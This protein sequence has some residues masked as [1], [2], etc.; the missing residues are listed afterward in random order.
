LAQAAAACDVSRF[1]GVG[2]CFEYDLSQGNLS[3]DTPLDPKTTYAAAKVATFLTLNQF[4]RTQG[5][6]F[7]WARL[8]YLYGSGDDPRRL[9]PYLH[10]KMQNGEVADLTSGNQIRDYMDVADAAKMLLQDTF[11]EVQGATNISSG[12][13]ITVRELAEKVADKYGRR[14]LLNFGARPDN[15]TDPPCVIGIRQNKRNPV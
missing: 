5:V 7:L 8:F 13:G 12:K 2:T 1:V 3:I 9:M 10:K 14:D 4:L 15:L 6:S 11:D